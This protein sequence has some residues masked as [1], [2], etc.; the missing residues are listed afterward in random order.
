MTPNWTNG[1]PSGVGYR[2]R[3]ARVWCG[4]YL[5]RYLARYFCAMTEIVP[6]IGSGD[7]STG[8]A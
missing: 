7:A 6:K 5:A 3:W 2:C 8:G 4:R 1:E